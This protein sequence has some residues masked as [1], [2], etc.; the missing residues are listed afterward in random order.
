MRNESSY[1]E[2]MK[3]SAMEKQ[4]K[5]NAFMLDLF[6]QMVIDESILK[7]KREKLLDLIDDALDKRDEK[8]FYSLS[9]QY[10]EMMKQIYK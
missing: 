5:D 4:R 3:K 9:Q 10:K 2:N 1:K 8:K 7:S 6:S